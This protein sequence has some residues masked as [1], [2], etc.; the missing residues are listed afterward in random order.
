MS[1]GYDVAVSDIGLVLLVIFGAVLIW[2]GPKVL[3]RIGATLGRGV[4]ETRRAVNEQIGGEDEH[5]RA[6]GQRPTD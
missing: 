1:L 4:R 5:P 2:R 6:E 3:P